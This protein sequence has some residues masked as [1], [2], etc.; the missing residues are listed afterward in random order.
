MWEARSTAPMIQDGQHGADIARFLL[1]HCCLSSLPD[2]CTLFESLREDR[3]PFFLCRNLPEIFIKTKL[4]G[5]P[6]ARK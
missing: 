4:S 3:L 2:S 6:L 1:F 5:V